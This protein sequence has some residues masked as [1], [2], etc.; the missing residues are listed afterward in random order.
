MYQWIS[1]LVHKVLSWIIG[2]WDWIIEKAYNLLIDILQYLIDVFVSLLNF[3]FG[4][5][6][7]S[8][9]WLLSAATPPEWVLQY[10]SFFNVIIPIDT[11]ILCIGAVMATYFWKMAASPVKKY[12]GMLGQSS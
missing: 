8:P 9:D 11:M 1:D 3:L 6:P 2:L 5:L 12:L 10:A 4:L 7:P